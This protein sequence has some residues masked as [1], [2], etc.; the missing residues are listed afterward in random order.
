MRGAWKYRESQ[1]LTLPFAFMF[2]E[3]QK[4]PVISLFL[5]KLRDLK[6]IRLFHPSNHFLWRGTINYLLGVASDPHDSTR[7]AR[8]P[9]FKGKAQDQA[10]SKFRNFD[11]LMA[12]MKVFKNIHI[13]PLEN[14][15]KESF[16]RGCSIPVLCVLWE[17]QF[18]ASEYPL[19]PAQ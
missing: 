19:N 14:L 13:M 1:V 17:P 8:V 12:N 2:L 9:V 15:Y 3:N 16:S 7:K 10:V 6:V 4:V 18:S 5:Y 11:T